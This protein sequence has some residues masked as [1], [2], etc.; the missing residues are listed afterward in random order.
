MWFLCLISFLQLFPITASQSTLSLSKTTATSTTKN[1]LPSAV[2]TASPALWNVT[3]PAEWDF[4]TILEITNL[5][6]AISNWSIIQNYSYAL[7]D[8]L[9]NPF[10][11]IDVVPAVYVNGSYSTYATNAL[12]YALQQDL[13][14]SFD[15]YSDENW[16]IPVV[17]EWPISGMYS[18]MQ[19]ILFY[20]LLVFA[21][22]W[23]HHEWLIAGAL[24]YATTYSGAA[25]VQVWVSRVGCQSHS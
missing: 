14:T 5:S 11:G 8:T 4:S 19:R 25:A 24:A 12:N 2:Y 7:L 18:L 17:C 21:L 1:P 22:V 20:V 6:I 23:R 10:P 9:P 13:N 16:A 15:A 3:V